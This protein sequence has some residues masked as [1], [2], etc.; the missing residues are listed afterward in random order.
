MSY[1]TRRGRGNS[2]P[3]CGSNQ[4][5][6]DYHKGESYCQVCGV[7]LGVEA[8]VGL[9]KGKDGELQ[10]RQADYSLGGLVDKK[11]FHLEYKHARYDSKVKV[12]D[13]KFENEM[14]GLI[15]IIYADKSASSMKKD[16][17]EILRIKR[18]YSE[19]IVMQTNSL[20]KGEQILFL[21]PGGRDS[22][23]HLCGLILTHHF[24]KLLDNWRANISV[25]EKE[26][27]QLLSNAKDLPQEY[28]LTHNPEARKTI[29]KDLKGLKHAWRVLST[30]PEYRAI[31]PRVPVTQREDRREIILQIYKELFQSRNNKFDSMIYGI[32]SSLFDQFKIPQT[33][34]SLRAF[35][36]DVERLRDGIKK[37]EMKKI[38][39]LDKY[40]SKS[41]SEDALFFYNQ[42]TK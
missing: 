34:S 10:A 31:I 33:R 30:L 36:W 3:E 27:N 8:I 29:L 32:D 4:I 19:Y 5:G 14:R 17:K 26:V 41:I 20:R 12:S 28:Q 40:P 7:I 37:S 16:L 11:S 42:L 13:S 39:P 38:C 22:G 35:V 25:S 6:Q 18:K 9:E 21:K 24:G 23:N 2:C 15:Q 1:T